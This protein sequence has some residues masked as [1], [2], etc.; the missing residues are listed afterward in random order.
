MNSDTFKET[1]LSTLAVAALLEASTSCSDCRLLYLKPQ[2][3]TFLRSRDKPHALSQAG[4]HSRLRSPE[5]PLGLRSLAD[6]CAHLYFQVESE[7]AA[8]LH[9]VSAAQAARRKGIFWVLEAPTSC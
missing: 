3:K 9:L 7:N 2:V 8:L 5:E 1:D 4:D 6:Q